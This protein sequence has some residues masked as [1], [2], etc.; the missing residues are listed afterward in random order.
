MA[1]LSPLESHVDGVINVFWKKRYGI[2]GIVIGILVIATFFL[3]SLFGFTFVYNYYNPQ[4]GIYASTLGDAITP[5]PKVTAIPTPQSLVNKCDNTDFVEQD[6]IT[7]HYIKRDDGYF[8]PTEKSRQKFLY[9]P[10]TLK[11]KISA[12]FSKIDIEFVANYQNQYQDSSTSAVLFLSLQDENK[13]NIFVLNFP[14]PNRKLVFIKS[15]IIPESVLSITPTAMPPITLL[16]RVSF[17]G[18][19]EI[20]ITSKKGINNSITYFIT[21]HYIDYKN[22]ERTFYREVILDLETVDPFIKEY[23]LNFATGRYGKI[24]IKKISLCD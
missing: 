18:T 22:I 24:K 11:N 20:I 5:I 19:H 17:N 16:S 15:D 13:K 2:K 21:G 1:N 8:S 6:W 23:S 7:S 4:K 9:P 10:I 3:F 14:E 12:A